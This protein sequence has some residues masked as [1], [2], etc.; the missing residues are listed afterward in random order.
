[1]GDEADSHLTRDPGKRDK[2]NA[3]WVPNLGKWMKEEGKS[4]SSPLSFSAS[5]LPSENPSGA[6]TLPLR[7]GFKKKNR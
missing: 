1:M 7:E 6:L 2:R 4:I 5:G 3:P